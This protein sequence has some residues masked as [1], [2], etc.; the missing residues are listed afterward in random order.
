MSLKVDSN[1]V[2]PRQKTLGRRMRE[3]WQLYLLLLVPLTYIIL[4]AYAPMGGLL[5]A[6]KN[7]DFTKGILG[8]EWVG[9]A[10]FE[11]F[12]NSTDFGRLI[13]NTLTLSIY[14]LAVGFPIPI[15]FAIAVH[16]LP[17][18]RFGKIVQ[19]TAFIPYFISTVVMV[20][21]LN[22]FFNNR[23]GIYGVFYNALTGS[24]APNILSNGPAFKNLYVWSSIWQSAGYD[25]IIYIAALSAVDISLHE[26]ASIDGASRFQR[27]L[28]IDIPAILPTVVILLIMSCGKIMNVGYEKV[29]LMQNNLNLR[30]S[31][32]ISTYVYKVGLTAR[33]DYSQATAIS[34]FNSVINFV[35]LISVNKLSKKCSGS[36]IF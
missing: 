33:S 25:A 6:F 4:F 36:G 24:I 34:M 7:Y 26:A 1:V 10:N 16:A 30:Y 17:S 8:S 35:L 23:I 29:F 11:R 19:T 32:V 27:V 5:I 18:K 15:I 14:R 3:R 31:E 2:I 21:L 28:H 20:G 9:F 12:F 13:R 22:Q